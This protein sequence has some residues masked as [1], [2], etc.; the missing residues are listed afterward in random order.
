MLAPGQTGP[1]A[2][3]RAGAAAA[4]LRS[5]DNGTT[6]ELKKAPVRIVVAATLIATLIAT[7]AASAAPGNLDPTFGTGGKLTTSFG[8]G[9][10]DV[11]ALVL[12]P[13]GKVVAA[14]AVW[15]GS[16]STFALARYNANGSLDPTFGRTGRMTTAFGAAGSG[17]FA[18]LLQ[19][20]GK[21]V[22]AGTATNGGS[23]YDFALVR[24]NANGSLDATFGTGGKV[25]TPI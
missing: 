16:A 7:A 11:Y 3:L 17:V 14:G 6:R 1:G 13:D 19:P 22:A 24:Y 12:Q 15:N 4:G 2:G 18:L 21:L 8:T 10:A 20:D 23:A 25:T 5:R 9:S